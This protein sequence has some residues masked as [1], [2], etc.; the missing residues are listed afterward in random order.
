MAMRQGAEQE[1]AVLGSA[2]AGGQSPCS[3]LG[4][5]S[6]VFPPHTRPG[7]PGPGPA[8]GG[9]QPTPPPPIPVQAPG[10]SER[11]P[12]NLQEHVPK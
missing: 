6:L 3:E 7:S 5:R 4:S 1:G 2:G 8:P 12:S 9:D 11:G 10:I